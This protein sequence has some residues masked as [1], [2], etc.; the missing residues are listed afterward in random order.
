MEEAALTTR[1]IR[2]TPKVTSGSTSTILQKGPFHL[3]KGTKL[4]EN[5]DPDQEPL[6][7]ES[8]L[9]VPRP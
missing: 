1:A 2:S 5:E 9:Y 6:Q 8:I 4:V 3:L 7:N